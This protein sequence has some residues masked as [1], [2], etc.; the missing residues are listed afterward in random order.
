MADERN[1][2]LLSGGQDENTMM[3]Y[4]NPEVLQSMA[5]VSAK[6]EQGF[7]ALDLPGRRRCAVNSEPQSGGEFAQGEFTLPEHINQE[8]GPRAAKAAWGGKKKMRSLGTVQIPTEAFM[9]VLKL[10]EE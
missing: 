2:G 7:R 3:V 1:D 9:A 6:K 4:I 8:R 5:D 10:D